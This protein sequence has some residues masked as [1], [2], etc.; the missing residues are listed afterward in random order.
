M[1]GRRWGAVCALAGIIAAT[2][3]F[4]AHAEWDP[5]PVTGFSTATNYHCGAQDLPEGALQGDVPKAD[6]DSGRAAKGYNCGL[7]LVGHTS[8]GDLGD[9][10][11]ATGNANMA[12]AGECAYVSGP[13]DAI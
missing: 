12:W 3:G 8:L 4:G 11:A 1:G 9:G 7:A 13:S 2:I 6:Q 5:N 10:R